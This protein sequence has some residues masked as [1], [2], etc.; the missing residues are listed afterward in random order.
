MLDFVRNQFDW[1]SVQHMD[2]VK[3]YLVERAGKVRLC[4]WYWNIGKGLNVSLW[5]RKK[6][7]SNVMNGREAIRAWVIWLR[8][9]KRK[10]RVFPTHLCGRIN[11]SIISEEKNKTIMEIWNNVD[12]HIMAARLLGKSSLVLYRDKDFGW[13]KKSHVQCRSRKENSGVA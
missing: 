5:I 12:W 2:T 10:W 6:R 13:I 9:W 11:R 4:G 3:W 8:W 1:R 7:R